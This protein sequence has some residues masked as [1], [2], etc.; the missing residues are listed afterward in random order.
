MLSFLKHVGHCLKS[1]KC[2]MESMA[3]YR[4]RSQMLFQAETVNRM[5]GNNFWRITQRYETPLISL[6]F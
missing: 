5:G 3:S 4:L 2:Y 1:S 6:S